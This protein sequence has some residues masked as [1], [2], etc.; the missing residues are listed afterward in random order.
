MKPADFISRFDSYFPQSPEVAEDSTLILMRQSVWLA[1]EDVMKRH[2]DSGETMKER[3]ARLKFA[4][5][6]IFDGQM[7]EWFPD[8]IVM[9]K[10][11]NDAINSIMEDKTVIQPAVQSDHAEPLDHHSHTPTAI[12]TDA[13]PQGARGAINSETA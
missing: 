9:L 3:A 13:M 6:R 7:M 4:I 1:V 5:N 10:K 2:L 11:C 8:M 12:H